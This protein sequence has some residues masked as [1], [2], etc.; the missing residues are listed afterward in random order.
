MPQD[1]LRAYRVSEAA[2]ALHMTTDEVREA[3]ARGLLWAVAI[4][5]ATR[6]PAEEVERVGE[7]SCAASRH[8]QIAGGAYSQAVDP[9]ASHRP[10]SGRRLQG[11]FYQKNS[12][13][14]GPGRRFAFGPMRD[15]SIHHPVG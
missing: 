1:L 12:H 4:D 7:I 9:H 11:L 10:P 15:T 3:I 5:K 13:Y 14:S 6:V 8:P 2:R